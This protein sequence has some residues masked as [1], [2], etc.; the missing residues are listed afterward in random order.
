MKVRAGCVT[1]AL[2]LL[3]VAV[4]AQTLSG[5]IE[6]SGGAGSST[7]NGQAQKNSSF[8]QAYTLGLSSPLINP[9]LVKLD[10]EVSFRAGSLNFTA[11]DNDQKGRQR[12][13]GYK[14][15]G[16]LFPAGKFPFTIQA[17]RDNVEESG[18]YPSFDGIRGGIVVP[19]GEPTPDFRTR[20]KALTMGWQLAVPKVPTVEFGYRKANSEV[21]GGPYYGEQRDDQLHLGVSQATARTQQSLRF[22]RN[23]FES[24]VSQAYNQRFD[25]LNYEFGA[26][27]SKG[28]HASAR[29][30]RRNQF[31]V[32]EV[33]SSSGGENGDAY[34]PPMRGEVS[35]IYTVSTLSYQPWRRIGFDVSGSIDRQRAAGVSTDARVATGSTRL[36]V[37]RGLSL[38]A[39]GTYGDRGQIVENVPI[40]VRT[41]TGL[42]GVTYRAG[43]GWLQGSV[44]YNVGG[45]SNTTPEGQTGTVKSEAGTAALSISIKGVGLSGG[46]ERSKATDELLDFGNYAIERSHAAVNTQAGRVTL[47]ASAERARV[48]RGRGATFSTNLQ[49]SVSGNVSLQIRRDSQVSANVGGFQNQGTFGNDRAMFAGVGLESQLAKGLHLSAWVRQGEMLASLTRLDQKT[50][51]GFASLEYRL[52]QFNLAVEYRNSRQNLMTSDLTDPYSFRGHQ[53]MLRLSRRFGKRL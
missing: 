41:K 12:D 2:V 50:A 28:F 36:D 48:E 52:R 1:C 30:G 16:T 18:T 43:V 29:V 20:T 33:P 34:R 22:D 51:Y 8:W 3:P 7:S 26:T 17:T 13:L 38:T 4:Q 5:S 42:A 19:P 37:V 23:A 31:S 46:Y 47:N 35:T 11:P 9:K 27:L 40:T 25:D 10:T 45:G 49:Q 24:P 14:L 15:G 21:T 39:L 32:F 44:G 6:G 53:V